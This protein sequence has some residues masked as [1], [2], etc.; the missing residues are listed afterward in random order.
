LV[1]PHYFFLLSIFSSIARIIAP[2]PGF[3]MIGAINVR[4]WLF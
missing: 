2:S 4:C 1:N 3:G